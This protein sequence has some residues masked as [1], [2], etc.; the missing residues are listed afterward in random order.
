MGVTLHPDATLLVAAVALDL[1]IGDPVYRFH[2]VRL[3]G[4]LLTWLEA[5]LRS[6]G[7]DGRGGGIALFVL[8]TLIVGGILH[9]LAILA[10][11][12][13]WIVHL[14]F[15]YSFLAL[16]DLLAHA[17]RV[18]REAQAH[19]LAGARSAIAMLVGRDT[20]SM[21]IEGCRR[22]AIESLSENLTDGFVSP[23]FWYALGGPPWPHDIQNRQHHGLHGR[24]QDS[25]LSL[26]RTV[27]RT[28][29]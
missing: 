9:A 11:S 27:R 23:L 14:F 4:N 19:G 20:Q 7:A 25:A 1:A 29:R 13:A 5:R 26:L 22:A 2:P 12:F 16:R 8:L 28:P 3:I 21:D 15:L 10:G 24:L 6:M 17:A 18:E